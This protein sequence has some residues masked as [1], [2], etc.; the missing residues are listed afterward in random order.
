M[1]LVRS[2]LVALCVLA[3]AH[4]SFA[5]AVTPPVAPS[6]APRHPSV[7]TI[8]KDLADDV[9]HLP[10]SENVFWGALGGGLAL[11]A[12]PFDAEVTRA[13]TGNNIATSGF[14][15]GRV[16][17]SFPMLMGSAITVYVI[18]RRHDQPRVS[19]VGMD[20]M[21]ALVISE[22]IVQPIK[23]IA[24]RERPD[25]S[26]FNSFPSGHT[27][28]TFAAAT[29]LERH[30][31]WKAGV[32]A[33]VAAT[34]VAISRVSARRHWLSDAA[35]GAGIG[36]MAGRTATWHGRAFPVVVARLPGGGFAVTYTR[37]GADS[38]VSGAA[39]AA[40]HAP[41]SRDPRGPVPD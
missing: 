20:L 36:I 6:P 5:Q 19:H 25:K 17:G 3:P 35:F 21:E 31:G 14:E 22:A 32:P 1:A 2:G 11:A 23:R 39:P 4:T 28:D 27:A 29:A 30:F 40:R 15:A 38:R 10:A 12:H 16:L 24:Q 26:A 33:Y 37:D 13:L 41:S 18:G 34:Y 8:F 9:K 7:K